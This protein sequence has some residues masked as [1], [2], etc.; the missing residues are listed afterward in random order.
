M[1]GQYLTRQTIMN[2]T[3]TFRLPF[4]TFLFRPPERRVLVNSLMC[5]K[6][7]SYLQ[8]VHPL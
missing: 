7:S 6:G 3:F 1:F 5:I 4:V 8:A 2:A